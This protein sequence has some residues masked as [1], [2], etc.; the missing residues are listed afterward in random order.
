MGVNELKER[1]IVV[2]TIMK[3]LYARNKDLEIG[4]QKA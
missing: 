4:V 2:E 3:K 1:L